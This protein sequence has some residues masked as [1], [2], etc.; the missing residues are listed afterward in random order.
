MDEI[1]LVDVLHALADPVRLRIIAK[2]ALD[3]T[4]SCSAISEGVDVHRTTMSHHYRVLRESGITWTTIEGR[5][6]YI[7]VRRDDLNARFP[8][9]LEAVLTAEGRRPAS[10]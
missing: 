10:R 4:E 1:N 9:L 7:T 2:L 6:R 3:G 8:G 5:T